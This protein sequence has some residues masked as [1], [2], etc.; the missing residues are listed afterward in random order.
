MFKMFIKLTAWFNFPIALGLMLPE[1]V[2]PSS[3]TLVI[4]VVLGAFLIFSGVALLWSTADLKTRSSIVVWNGLVRCVGFL[5]VAYAWSLGLSP[6]IFVV[7]GAMDLVTAAI[8]FI[9]SVRVSG[10]SFKRLLLGG[11]PNKNAAI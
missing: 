5:V 9:G 10:L 1:L 11:S 3:D 7:I 2:I 4:G 8:Y 6:L